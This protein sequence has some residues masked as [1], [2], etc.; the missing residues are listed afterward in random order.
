MIGTQ[1]E[2]SIHSGY[3][4]QTPKSRLSRASPSAGTRNRRPYFIPDRVRF[5][6]FILL[7]AQREIF[8]ATT[9]L[10]PEAGGLPA[11]PLPDV[12]D[13][14]RHHGV[15][16]DT[17]SAGILHART[18]HSQALAAALSLLGGL[19]YSGDERFCTWPF[20]AVMALNGLQ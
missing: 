16:L 15:G 5:H 18:T 13:P 10:I 14:R 1:S 17:N 11:L 4:W 20:S 3:Y 8:R 9:A 6:S 7:T 19:R 2:T 12:A